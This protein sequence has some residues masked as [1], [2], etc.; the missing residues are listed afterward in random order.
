MKTLRYGF[1]LRIGPIVFRDKSQSESTSMPLTP[2]EFYKLRQNI[3]T[4]VL[5]INLI[6]HAV[7][8]N[9]KHRDYLLDS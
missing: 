9:V 7:S 3:M 4:C 6:S 5:L 1:G 8:V 2:I